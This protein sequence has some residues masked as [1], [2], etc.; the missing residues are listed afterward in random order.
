MNENYNSW[1]YHPYGTETF[2]RRDDIPLKIKRLSQQERE[3]L[4]YYKLSAVMPVAPEGYV[5]VATGY[6]RTDEGYKR[7]Y[8][9]VELPKPA[10]NNRYSVRA[11]IKELKAIDK[12]ETVKEVLTK[13]NVDWEFL[14]S[15][16]LADGDEDFEKM[17]IAIV[18]LGIMTAEELDEMLKKCYW[19]ED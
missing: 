15:N 1:V 3:A 6:E 13:G 17:K 16:Y 4:G 19:T 5:Y 10:F 14:G 9:L 18:N 8:E 11:V 12:F 2:L 7:V